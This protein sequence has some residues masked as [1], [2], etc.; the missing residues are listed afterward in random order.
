MWI[1]RSGDENAAKDVL[2]TIDVGSVPIRGTVIGDAI[3]VAIKGLEREKVKTG[4]W[5]FNRL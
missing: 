1:A 2:D 3:R 5:F 4:C